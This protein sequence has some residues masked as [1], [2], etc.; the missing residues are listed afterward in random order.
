[1]NDFKFSNNNEC[2]LYGLSN[3][4]NIYTWKIEGDPLKIEQTS[5]LKT[6]MKTPTI[7]IPHDYV[8]NLLYVIGNKNELAICDNSV[9]KVVE[10]RSIPDVDRICSVAIPRNE[11]SSVFASD[12]LGNVTSID[13]RIGHTEKLFSFA[14]K[15]Q[16]TQLVEVS[17][18]GNNRLAVYGTELMQRKIKI[19]D[20]KN[21][22]E[23]LQ[24][25]QLDSMKPE[26][27]IPYFDE[28]TGICFSAGNK[29]EKL[30]AHVI[31]E[32]GELKEVMPVAL[33]EQA[34]SFTMLPKSVI[35][36]KKVE[37]LRMLTLQKDNTIK[38]VSILVPKKNVSIIFT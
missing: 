34:I 17:K 32:N 20:L 35:D 36:V 9:Q 15:L 10:S 3:A 33:K 19:Y 38:V 16:S 2:I 30:Y 31:N 25:V 13:G 28:D 11:R 37:I 6:E 12:T 24:V 5:L 4:S 8:N 14:S 29:I 21:P 22:K 18:Y 1:M 23:A 26:P 7:L 27:L